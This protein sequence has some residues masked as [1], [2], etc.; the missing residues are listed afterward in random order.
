[1]IRFVPLALALAALLAP[2]GAQASKAPPK[3]KPAHKARVQRVPAR[4]RHKTT[5][6]FIPP[7]PDRPDPFFHVM[8][9]KQFLV[10]D[11]LDYPVPR[12]VNRKPDAAVVKEAQGHE[13]YSATDSE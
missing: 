2:L 9:T 12:N 4:S 8:D 10:V 7:N 6:R 11:G 1:M 5:A 3:K 13:V